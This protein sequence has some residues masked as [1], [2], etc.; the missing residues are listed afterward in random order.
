MTTGS[1][2]KQLLLVVAQDSF[3]GRFFYYVAIYICCADLLTAFAVFEIYS[4]YSILVL[5][6]ASAVFSFQDTLAGLIT[7]ES[8]FI[9]VGDWTLTETN[10]LLLTT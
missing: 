3:F 8:A 10:L 6:T 5:L 1:L 9:S 7:Q 2:A 4:H